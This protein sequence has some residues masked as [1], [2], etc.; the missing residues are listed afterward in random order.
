MWE[1]FGDTQGEG[2]QLKEEVGQEDLGK[3]HWPEIADLEVL[4]SW[5]RTKHWRDQSRRALVWDEEKGVILESLGISAE[6]KR[7][8]K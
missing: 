8:R 1:V 2:Y 6:Q 7:S 3:A 5:W 4:V